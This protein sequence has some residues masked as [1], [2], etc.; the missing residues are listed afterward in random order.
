M[1]NQ[2]GHEKAN[3]LRRHANAVRRLGD[4]KEKKKKETQRIKNR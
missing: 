3:L 4:A 1:G 2:P